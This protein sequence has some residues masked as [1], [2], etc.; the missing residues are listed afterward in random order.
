METENCEARKGAGERKKGRAAAWASRLLVL[1]SLALLLY[2]CHI[3]CPE[4]EQAARGWLT[5]GEQSRAAQAF[6]AVAQSLREGDGVTE[7]FS[8]GYQVLTGDEN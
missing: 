1:A 5:R 8:A 2:T 6:S 3:C 7:A 4:A